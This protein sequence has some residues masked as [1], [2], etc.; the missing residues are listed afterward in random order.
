MQNLTMI[1][2]WWQNAPEPESPSAAVPRSFRLRL[3]PK[4]FQAKQRV[5]AL[6]K[7]QR[8]DPESSTV[9]EAAAAAVQRGPKSL[10]L[11]KTFSQ[12]GDGSITLLQFSMAMPLSGPAKSLV[13]ASVEFISAL[14]HLP[15]VPIIQEVT[16]DIMS[17]EE[18]LQNYF[19]SLMYPWVL[20]K[21]GQTI[22]RR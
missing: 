6:W 4:K 12:N 19:E 18:Q 13:P 16:L 3:P 2:K 11:S 1:C 5:L 20:I 9:E 10:E 14:P 21:A 17:E 15:D 7:K 22:F 8:R